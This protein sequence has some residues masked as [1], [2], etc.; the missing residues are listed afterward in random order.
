MGAYPMPAYPQAEIG[1][2]KANVGASH[3][4][5]LMKTYVLYHDD[6]DGFGAAW[7]HKRCLDT[8]ET[9]YYVPC[10]YQQPIPVMEEGA[11]Y[12]LYDI[13]YPR[14]AL[15][16]LAEMAESVTVVDHHAASVERMS[17]ID[18]ERFALVS[19]EKG[20]DRSAAYL[21][22]LMGGEGEVPPLVA[23]VDDRDRWQFKLMFSRAVSYWI[24][25]FGRTFAD[26]DRMNWLLLT[27]R[28]KV[29][30]AALEI[31]RYVDRRI[32]EK[33]QR[34]TKAQITLPG[35][36]EDGKLI[37]WEFPLVHATEHISDIAATMLEAEPE[38]PFAA[39]LYLA[40]DGEYYR[41][42]F[43]SRPGGFDVSELA[44][45]FGGGGH[46]AAAGLT[47]PLPIHGI[48]KP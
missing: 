44:R 15:Y 7:V 5:A 33:V 18:H 39:V 35:L 36:S 3:T 47:V 14:A 23:Y 30:D 45:Q 9:H 48:V 32:E 12:Y 27:R 29:Y 8:D 13:S 40:S 24:R 11:R 10:A 34:R 6:T 26:W 31:E 22:W 21:A 1:R 46:P 2:Y 28:A 20:N 38:A 25:S 43:R 42:S 17:E 16:A 4:E 19:P 37:T 41:Y